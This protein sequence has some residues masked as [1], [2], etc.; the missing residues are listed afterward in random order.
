MLNSLETC[1]NVYLIF[2][3]S[4]RLCNVPALFSVVS[5][6]E[7]DKVLALGGRYVLSSI[8]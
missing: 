3:S 4:I 2:H 6:I 1:K 8:F 7:F 5:H